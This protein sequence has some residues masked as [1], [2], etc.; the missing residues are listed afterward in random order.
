M[1]RLRPV[2]ITRA[3]AHAFIRA[4]HRHHLPPVGDVFRVALALDG[5]IIGVATVGRPVARMLDNGWTA[6]VT[7]CCVAD[8]PEAK[9]AA[10]KLYAMAWRIAREMGYTRLISYT[11]KNESGT[12]LIAAGWKSMYQTR[13]G[14]SWDV[15]SRPRVDKHPLGAKTL[16][17]AI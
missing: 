8:V 9:H 3:E 2:P 11:L 13:D 10:S 14:K 12:S 17:E 16:W 4:H 6:E 5:A 7:R 1:S 15:P